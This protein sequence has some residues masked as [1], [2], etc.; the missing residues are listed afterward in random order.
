[1]MHGSTTLYN[2]VR[3][4]LFLARRYIMRTNPW[5]TVLVVFVM[6]LTFLNLVV[7]NGILIGL[8]DGALL[9]YKVNYAGDLLIQKLPEKEQIDHASAILA[10]L[11]DDPGVAAYSPRIVEAGTIEA[12]YREAVAFPDQVR[13]R[14]GVAIVG[15]DIRK[16]AAVTS[17]TSSMVEGEFL[18][19]A[20]DDSVVIG[21]NLIDRYFPAAIG[22]QTLSNVYPGDKVRVE[23]G[24]VAREF[25]VKGIVRTKADNADLRVYMLVSQLKKMRSGLDSSPLDEFAI[26]LAPDTPLE[27]VRAR[28]LSYGIGALALVQTSEEAI[29]EFIDEIKDTFSILGNIIGSIS[30]IVASITIFII[31]FITAITRQKYIGILKGIGISRL[32][33]EL[34]Y[35]FLS[36]FYSV[37]GIAGGLL[38]LYLVLIPYFDANPIDFPFSWGVLSVTEIGVAL[39]SMILV[40][41]TIIAGYIPAQLIVKRNTLDSIL[42][43]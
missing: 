14:V 25:K 36:V 32:T 5:Q 15:L 3:V 1:M 20:D 7:V 26:K 22:L 4:A 43:R 39:R 42:G 12:S 18:T 33:I 41:T 35:V 8:I 37:L 11:E 13:D 9:G 19:E 23:I 27:T 34:S 21:G 17:L 28:I 16:E 30:V 2:T 24:N 10:V 29:G 31:I 6:T 38:I 40:V